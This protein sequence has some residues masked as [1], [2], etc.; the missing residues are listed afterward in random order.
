MLGEHISAT[1]NIGKE[2]GSCKHRHGPTGHVDY[3]DYVDHGS[4]RTPGPL[5]E[6]RG[7]VHN[8]NPRPRLRHSLRRSQAGA[9]PAWT[10][11]SPPTGSAPTICPFRLGGSA[12]PNPPEVWLH[13]QAPVYK[14]SP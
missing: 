4:P 7:H 2:P 5:T 1:R 10:Q 14:L 6:F 11:H 3:M 9:L 13:L 12:L 8:R